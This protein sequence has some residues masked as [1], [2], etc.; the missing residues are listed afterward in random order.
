M[1]KNEV[2][3]D[4]TFEFHQKMIVALAK[5]NTDTVNALLYD[6]TDTHALINHMAFGLFGEVAEVMENLVEGKGR[7]NLV[8]EL[9]DCE[10]YLGRLAQLVDYNSLMLIHGVTP[11]LGST[12]ALNATCYAVIKAGNIMDAVKRLT[13]Y[14]KDLDVEDLAKAIKGMAYCL[15]SIRVNS[16]ITRQECFEHN[17]NKLGKRYKGGTYSNQSAQERADKPEGE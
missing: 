5:S 13:T 17:I 7:E 8:E 2:V 10:F 6:L 12:T 4:E 15:E 3:L 14:E 16:N 1:N 9:G 11:N